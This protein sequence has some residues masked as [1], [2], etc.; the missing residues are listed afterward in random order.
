M[1]EPLL[2][3]VPTDID[4]EAEGCD[5][6]AVV[7]IA[8]CLQTDRVVSIECALDYTTNTHEAPASRWFHE[9]S[10][11]ITCTP[12]D[13]GELPFSTQD[14]QTARRYIPASIRPLVM[15]IVVQSC[16]VLIQRVRPRSLYRVT[17]MRRPTTKA[18]VKHQLITSRLRELGYTLYES[19]TDPYGRTYWLMALV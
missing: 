8:R 2:D 9:F 18:L 5:Y 13:G 3:R 16:T 7:P 15:P 19:G 4:L 17:K 6:S 11:S 14:P 1:F 12:L 10:F